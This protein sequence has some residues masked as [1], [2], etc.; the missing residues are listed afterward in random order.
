ML[1]HRHVLLA[2][3]AWTDAALTT[4]DSVLGGRPRKQMTR[5]GHP[6]IS[7]QQMWRQ[8]VL[9]CLCPA[10][11]MGPDPPFSQ[12]CSPTRQMSQSQDH[13]LPPPQEL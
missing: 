5:E 11:P 12:R 7:G 10:P 9:I 4:Q 13:H 8:G 2:Q 6:Q 1:L 3:L